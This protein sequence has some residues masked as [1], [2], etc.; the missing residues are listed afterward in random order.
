MTRAGS[1]YLHARDTATRHA[2]ETTSQLAAARKL[3]LRGAA[4]KVPPHYFADAPAPAPASANR[5]S[6]I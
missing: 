2:A 3:G 4:G 1:M 6:A 5:K